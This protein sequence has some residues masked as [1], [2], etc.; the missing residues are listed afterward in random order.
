MIAVVSP[1]GDDM[2]QTQA[3]AYSF[4]E[5]VSEPVADHLHV[6][7]SY[8]LLVANVRKYAERICNEDT[9]AEA[10]SEDSWGEDSWGEDSWG[11]DS[12]GDW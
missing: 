4:N 7:G 3:M 5:I 11:E 2:L 9:H 6:E 8:A 12:W 10:A 1:P